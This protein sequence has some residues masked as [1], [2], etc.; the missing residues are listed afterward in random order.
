MRACRVTTA[1]CAFVMSGE[2]RVRL[3]RRGY[4]YSSI[5]ATE[6]C[7]R[8]QPRRGRSVLSDGRRPNQGVALTSPFSYD[9]DYDWQ[10]DGA[11]LD[12]RE[13]SGKKRES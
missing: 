11:E 4:M 12:L 9:Y 1:V 6:A 7:L 8:Q 13:K 3:H 5:R 10:A 2:C